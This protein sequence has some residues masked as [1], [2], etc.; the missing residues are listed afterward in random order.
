MGVLRHAGKRGHA[1]HETYPT[2]NPLT[3]SIGA[4][5]ELSFDKSR[6]DERSAL[7]NRP[8]GLN[9][10][11]GQLCVDDQ[12]ENRHYA[13]ENCQRFLTHAVIPPIQG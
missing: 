11:Y 12:A 2:L 6:Y 10:K 1:A 9:D 8:D 7:G 3:H 5:Y 4:V 13:N